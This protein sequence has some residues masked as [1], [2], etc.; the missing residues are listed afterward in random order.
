M[1]SAFHSARMDRFNNNS[2]CLFSC[3]NQIQTMPVNR[4]A[5]LPSLFMCLTGICDYPYQ[6]RSQD[7]SK[8]GLKLWKQKP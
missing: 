5:N 6:G 4:I 3:K 2:L 1:V 7:F 8:G